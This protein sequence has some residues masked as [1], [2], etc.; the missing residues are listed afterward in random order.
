MGGTLL[1]ETAGPA[2]TVQDLG[3]PGAAAL[4][5]GPSGALDRGALR[6]AN[7]LVGNPEGRAALEVVLGPFAAVPDVDLWIAVTGAWGAITVDGRP[8][9]GHRAVRV[10]AGSRLELGAATHGLR[11]VLA[12]RGGFDGPQLL[13]S[14]ST[15]TLAGLGPAPVVGGDRLVVL[16]TPRRRVPPL[17]IAPWT[18]PEA[19][20]RLIR[21]SPGPRRNWFD[22]GSLQR[23]VE[24]SWSVTADA[25]RIGMRLDGTPLERLDPGR[26]LPS[27]G[28]V[29]GAVQVPPSGLPTILAAD[30]PVTGGY[31]VIAVVR[32]ADRDLLAQLRPGQRLRFSTG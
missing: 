13:G 14:R 25:D 23:L 21:V 16:P 20:E 4:G 19:G 5:V 22:A 32:A 12:V 11:Y 1:V 28:M 26:E 18:R 30:H 9:D 31:P 15:D 17:D 29:A 2:T 3:R 7:R 10:A 6:L 8:V 24:Q 27:E